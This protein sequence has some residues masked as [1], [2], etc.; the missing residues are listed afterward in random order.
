MRVFIRTLNKEIFSIDVESSDTVKLKIEERI[1]RSPSKQRL[2]TQTDYTLQEPEKLTDLKIQE[3]STINIMYDDPVRIHLFK[4]N[5]DSTEEFSQRS[6]AQ[7]FSNEKI[8]QGKHSFLEH[9]SSAEC[10]HVERHSSSE[11]R[12]DQ[13]DLIDEVFDCTLQG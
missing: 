7:D 12:A 1:G 3:G 6:S 11:V 4:K 9:S 10:V 2:L 5:L 13:S 8:L